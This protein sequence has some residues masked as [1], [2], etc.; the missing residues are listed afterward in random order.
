[1]DRQQYDEQRYHD[2]QAM[3]ADQD[4]MTAQQGDQGLSTADLAGMGTQPTAPPGQAT[5]LEDTVREERPTTAAQSP[6]HTT[7]AADEDT[8]GPL[9]GDTESQGMRTRWDEIQTGFVDDPRQAVER[10]DQLVAEAMKRLAETFANER[11]NLEGQWSR[12]DQADTEDLR[13]AL[14]RYRAFFDRLLSI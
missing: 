5:K 13:V 4:A 8:S 11:S 1:M 2:R 6:T 14:R 10:A 9:L 7:Q 12:G 3:S